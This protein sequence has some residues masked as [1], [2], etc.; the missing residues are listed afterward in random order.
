MS[1]DFANSFLEYLQS[2]YD[3]KDNTDKIKRRLNSVLFNDK[4]IGLYCINSIT[5]RNPC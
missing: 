5:K 1:I 3:S 2:N 4:I